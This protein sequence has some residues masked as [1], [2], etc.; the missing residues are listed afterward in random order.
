MGKLV[1][2]LICYYINFINIDYYK[3]LYQ[4]SPV[5]CPLGCVLLVTILVPPTQ[6]ATTAFVQTAISGVGGT[7]IVTSSTQPS[8]QTT[9]DFWYKIL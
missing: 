2:H 7:S 8:G 9:G 1:T 3:I 6:I 5:V 4:K